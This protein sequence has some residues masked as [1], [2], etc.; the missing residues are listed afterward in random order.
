MKR[1]IISVIILVLLVGGLWAEEEEAKKPTAAV[2]FLLTGSFAPI[3][4]GAELFLGNFGIG[5]TFTALY[6][7]FGGNS[8][9]FL[10]PG[11]YAHFYF[12]DLASSFYLLV[13]TSYF[14]FGGSYEGETKLIDAGLLKFNAGIGYNALFGKKGNTRFAVELGPRYV[15]GVAEGNISEEGLILVHFML[16]FGRAF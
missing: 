10:E 4:I 12:S 1:V 5:V 3:G 15:K 16:M 7:G 8:I 11:A 6:F 13:G 9:F 2:S 14:T